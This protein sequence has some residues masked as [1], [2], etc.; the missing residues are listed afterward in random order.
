MIGCPS[1][2]E[3]LSS[4]WVGLVE[5]TIVDICAVTDLIF[6]MINLLPLPLRTGQKLHQKLT[7]SAKKGFALNFLQS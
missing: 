6:Q 2:I 4:K 3:G 5:M 7:K 1:Q